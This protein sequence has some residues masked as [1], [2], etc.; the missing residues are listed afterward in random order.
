MKL[1]LIILMILCYALINMIGEEIDF[2]I[3]NYKDSR[4]K[5]ILRYRE[6]N[7]KKLEID[8][9]GLYSYNI[10]GYLNGRELRKYYKK[11]KYNE[12]YHTE[13]EYNENKQVL[14]ERFYKGVDLYHGYSNQ[15]EFWKYYYD[16]NMIKFERLRPDLSIQREINYKYNENNDIVLVTNYFDY[17]YL[18]GDG[19]AT[20]AEVGENRFKYEYEKN[21]KVRYLYIKRYDR[22][23]KIEEFF[24]NENK[25]LNKITFYNIY[26]GELVRNIYLKYDK[27]NNVSELIK[28]DPDKKSYR[29]YKF[30]YDDKNRLVKK[31]EYFYS[32][33]IEDAKI[34]YV[35]EYFYEDGNYQYYPYLLPVKINYYSTPQYPRLV[36]KDIF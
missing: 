29:L 18:P 2:N 1:K 27:N 32:K 28:E 8:Q 33:T 25:F 22:F 17:N 36:D 26:S 30:F 31:I 24:Y 6:G 19:F 13:I 35:E 23:N 15:V 9:E 10:E 21:K 16:N 20:T 3:F 5:K 4:L 34:D 14:T 7:F 12:L 11:N